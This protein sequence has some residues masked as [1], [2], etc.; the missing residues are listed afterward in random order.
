MIT[1]NSMSDELTHTASLFGETEKIIKTA[2]QSYLHTRCYDQ[3]AKAQQHIEEYEQKYQ[4]N[5]TKLN[6][7][8]QIDEA[9]LQQIQQQN[10][11][12]EEKVMIFA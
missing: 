10:P 7:K 4:Y 3:I 2:L 5:Y 6:H 8:I 12:W 9:F 1:L 11:L